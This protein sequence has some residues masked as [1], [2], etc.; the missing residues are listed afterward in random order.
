MFDIT[1]D[2]VLS[3]AGHH[4]ADQEWELAPEVWLSESR[5]A[6]TRFVYTPVVLEA[7]QPG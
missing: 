4:A 1:S 2:P 6:A 7:I 5:D 3:T